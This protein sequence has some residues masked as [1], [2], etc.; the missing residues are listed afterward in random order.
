MHL[1]LPVNW[2]QGI[3][4]STDVQVDSQATKAH[5]NKCTL[6]HFLR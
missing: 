4:I 2:A 5:Q 3:N 1:F 6:F